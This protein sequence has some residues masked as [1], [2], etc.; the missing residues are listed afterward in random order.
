MAARLLP[1]YNCNDITNP[2]PSFVPGRRFNEREHIAIS[3]SEHNRKPVF[4]WVVILASIFFTAGAMHV[5]NL[6]MGS[7]ARTADQGALFSVNPSN[8]NRTLISDFN[9]STQ[10]SWARASSICRQ[11]RQA[12]SWSW[13]LPP[14]PSGRP[15]YSRGMLQVA[16]ARWSAT[17]MIHPKGHWGK[18]HS[19]WSSY[20][21]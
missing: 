10:G 21:L 17:S 14:A 5:T 16:A 6:T 1:S 11:M 3:R 4:C 2:P 15:R 12:K 18:R 7:G 20:R 8:G 9:N 19:V 13:I